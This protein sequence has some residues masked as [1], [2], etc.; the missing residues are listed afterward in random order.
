MTTP[1]DAL[2]DT[3]STLSVIGKKGLTLLGISVRDLQNQTP[4]V[5]QM[6]NGST[7]TITLGISLTFGIGPRKMKFWF[8]YLETLSFPVV[9]GLDFIREAGIV[10]D[11]LL[12]QWHF[13]ALPDLKFNFVLT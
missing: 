3:G 8:A 13:A 11:A 12:N 9:L 1:I 5:A 7:T 10:A 2:L 6:A 4:L